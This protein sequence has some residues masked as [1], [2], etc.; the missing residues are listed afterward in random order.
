MS[1]EAIREYVRAGAGRADLPE[2]HD[3]IQAADFQADRARKVIRA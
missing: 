1:I 3:P 2:R